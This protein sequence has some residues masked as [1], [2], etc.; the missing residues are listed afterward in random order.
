M[1]RAA[2]RSESV[3]APQQLS[4]YNRALAEPARILGELLLDRVRRERAQQRAA[5]GKDAEN[6]ADAGAAQTNGLCLQIQRLADL[7]GLAQQ[8]AVALRALAECLVKLSEH[9][10]R[11]CTSRGNVLMAAQRAAKALGVLQ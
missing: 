5:A 8:M 10:Q 1:R 2:R 3:T 7:A 9:G 4:A 6:R 11:E